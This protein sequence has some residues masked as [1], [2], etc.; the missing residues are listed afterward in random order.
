MKPLLTLLLLATPAHAVQLTALGSVVKLT[1]DEVAVRGC[2]LKGQIAAHPPY[3]LPNDWEIQL[4]NQAGDLGANTV[5]HKRPGFGNVKGTA[6]I[7]AEPS[8][9]CTKDTDCKGDRICEA[10]VC[11]AP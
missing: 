7:C 8:S 11:K 10:G 6:Y 3:V 5:L 9:G 2:E 1:T 4:R